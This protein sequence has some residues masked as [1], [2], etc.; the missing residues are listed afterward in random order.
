MKKGIVWPT[1]CGEDT[2][3]TQPDGKPCPYLTE[4]EECVLANE[5]QAEGEK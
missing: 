4:N 2:D 3:C 1:W 5:E